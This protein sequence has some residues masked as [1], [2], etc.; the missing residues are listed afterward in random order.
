MNDA[1]P[2]RDSVLAQAFPGLGIGLLV[3]LLVGLSVSPVVSGVLTTLGGLLGAM[4]GLQ[5]DGAD[6]A[7]SGIARFRI[8]GLRIG[9][10]GFA[11][12]AGVLA[13]LAIRVH[14]A[15]A[16]PLEQQVARWVAAGYSQEEA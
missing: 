11:C 7:A 16:I 4:L 8:N 3:G 6:G 12:V 2:S 13:G 10:F 5:S 14:D 1:A 15:F 9:M